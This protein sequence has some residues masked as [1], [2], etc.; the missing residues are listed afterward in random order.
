M[1]TFGAGVFHTSVLFIMTEGPTEGVGILGW[2]RDT[3]K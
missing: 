1:A 2:G 3:S